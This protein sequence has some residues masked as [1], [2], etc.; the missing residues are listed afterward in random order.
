MP[1]RVRPDSVF[2]L[3]F[4]HEK[5]DFNPYDCTIP[6]LIYQKAKETK[7][8]FV[9]DSEKLSLSYEG[10]KTE[11]ESLATGFL[12]SGLQ[13]NDRVLIC[14]YNSHLVL[15]S[16]LA[17]SRAGLIFSLASP[18]FTHAQQLKHLIVSGGFRAVILFAPNESG[19]SDYAYNM[20]IEICPELKGSQRG[21]LASPNLPILS[22]VILGDEDHK[23][24]GCYTLS[25]IFGKCSKQRM[26]KLPNYKQ[27]NCHRMAA[28]SF[29]LGATGPQK[30]VCLSHYQLINSCRLTA[31]TIGISKDA[32]FACALPIYRIPVFCLIAL[33]PFFF[34]S[35]TVISEPSPI[36]RFLFSTINKYKCTTLLSNAVAIRLLIKAGITQKIKLPS[37][38]SVMPSAKKIAVGMLFTETGS[39]PILSDKT[40]NMLKS[41]GK[42]LDGYQVDIKP[43]DNA[44]LDWIETGDIASISRE[45]NV[46]ILTNKSDLIYDRNDKLV[47]HWVIEKHLAQY[48]EIKGVQ[49]VQV[50]H[51]APVCCIVVPKKLQ[52][53]PEFIR[54]DL[55]VICRKN[56]MY[57]PDQFAIITDFPRVNT[58]IQKFKLREMLKK[59]MFNLY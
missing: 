46:E 40:T 34:N 1:L 25:E 52:C 38:N 57:I 12:S 54:T 20:M 55:T 37:V 44:C 17:A 28:I 56:N 39:V 45:G 42:A 41:I 6:E 21:K 14:G 29:T 5:D 9:F 49:L 53:V 10:L 58:R 48:Q 8:A 26:E 2:C 4:T 43:V 7:T 59:K 35:C 24:S 30:A 18:N 11:M 23:H 36:P 27:W 32:I 50:C 3:E 22:H 13:P 15:I 47:E 33:T 51:G 16:A 19:G 31:N